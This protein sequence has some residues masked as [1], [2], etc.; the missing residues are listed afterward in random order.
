MF[1][2]NT[3]SLCNVRWVWK[4]ILKG[5][6]TVWLVKLLA[7]LYFKEGTNDWSFPN[8]W[9]KH[10]FLKYLVD[11]RYSSCNRFLL[12]VVN[13]LI[14]NVILTTGGFYDFLHISHTHGYIMDRDIQN[15]RS[16]YSGSDS[17]QMTSGQGLYSLIALL[18]SLAR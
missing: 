12:M 14:L 4:W 18:P 2:K 1:V 15:W 8:Y 7:I 13:L 16:S 5:V 11:S 3:V 10:W 9:K 6:N 17:I